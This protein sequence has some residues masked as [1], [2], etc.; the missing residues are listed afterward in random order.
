M[1]YQHRFQVHAPLVQ[2]AEFHQ[3]TASMAAITP[4]PIITQMRRAPA[5]L[6]EGDEMEF[7]L[8]LGPLPVRWVARIEAVSVNGFTD[9][10]LSG[11]FAKW[12]HHHIF[13]AVDEQTTEVVDEISLRLRSHPLWWL[14]GMGMRLGLP[15]LFAFRAWKTKGMLP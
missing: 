3:R 9:R 15:A 1:I 8:W 5:V 10:Q 11:P 6:G 12:V 14:V 7:T 4:P 13:T 2:V